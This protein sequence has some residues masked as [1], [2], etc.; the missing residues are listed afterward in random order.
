[1]FFQAIVSI[2]FP[3]LGE[4]RERYLY[5]ITPWTQSVSTVARRGLRLFYSDDDTDNEEE[6]EKIA[7]ATAYG[8][9]RSPKKK[10]MLSYFTLKNDLPKF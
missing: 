10:G 8:L 1:M 6:D 9:F 7:I 4:M 5:N 3:E 2:N